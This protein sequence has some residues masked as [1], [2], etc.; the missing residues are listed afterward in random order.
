MEKF[1]SL[2]FIVSQPVLFIM[3]F[4]VFFTRRYFI[5]IQKTHILETELHI[6]LVFSLNE[7]IIPIVS[8]TLYLN[9]KY[10]T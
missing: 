2:V 4:I 8:F 9:T 3:Y 5:S 1:I 7:V 10:C 6:V